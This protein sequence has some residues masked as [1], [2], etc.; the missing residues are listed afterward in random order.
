MDRNKLSVIIA[1]LF[2]GLPMLMVFSERSFLK[3]AG[4]IWGL[5]GWFFFHKCSGQKMKKK[6]NT[7]LLIKAEVA[8][9]V[10]FLFLFL[11]ACTDLPAIL[12]D[13]LGRA[14]EAILVLVQ[15][16]DDIGKV[17]FDMLKSVV[18]AL[19]ALGD[20]IVK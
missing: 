4:F 13:V 9:L 19:Y 17:A 2:F 15:M 12:L 14:G 3:L 16:F 1:L 7:F 18:Q 6:M 10:V 5:C 20:M 11:I 8:L